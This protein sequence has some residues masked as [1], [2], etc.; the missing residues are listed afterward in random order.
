VTTHTELVTKTQ[1]RPL[2]C[3]WRMPAPASGE[4]LDKDRVNVTL[5]GSQSLPLGRVPGA[6]KCQ[7]GAW[8]YDDN[9]APTELVACP[10][11]CA[12]IEAGTYTDV[13]I[14]LGCET[15]ILTIL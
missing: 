9:A 2:A 15:K 3:H 13:K 5:S 7:D 4:T 6:D 1:Q 10:S 8:Y 14:L 11:A 12:A